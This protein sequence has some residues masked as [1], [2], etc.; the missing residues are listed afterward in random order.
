MMWVF[1]HDFPAA[2]GG[3]G[4]FAGLFGIVAFVVGAT[5]VGAVTGAAAAETKGGLAVV[6]FG[7]GEPG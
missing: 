5:D 2:S 6:G 3:S 7:P 1:T 4:F